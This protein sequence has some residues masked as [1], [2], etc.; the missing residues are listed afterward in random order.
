MNV[1]FSVTR[2]CGQ[3]VIITRASVGKPESENAT[4]CSQKWGHG[5][6]RSMRRQQN[7]RDENATMLAC[8]RIWCCAKD[9]LTSVAPY[10]FVSHTKMSIFFRKGRSSNY[11]LESQPDKLVLETFS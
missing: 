4:V 11:S 9:V 3:L 5:P 8:D 2:V 1:V 10:A 6:R 7:T